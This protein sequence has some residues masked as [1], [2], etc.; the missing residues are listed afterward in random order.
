MTNHTKLSA[1]DRASLINDA[2]SLSSAGMLD[3]SIALS[4]LSYLKDEKS[5]TVWS[6]AIKVLDDLDDRLA[7]TASYPLFKRV[8]KIVL[9]V[10]LFWTLFCLFNPAGVTR[11]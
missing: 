7:D 1:M 11:L 3:Y 6:T 10:R 2:F 5:Y 9:L 4:I 8:R